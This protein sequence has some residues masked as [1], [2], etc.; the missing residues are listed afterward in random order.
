MSN[1]SSFSI[2][3]I[4]A[5]TLALLAAGCVVQPPLVS[6]ATVQPVPVA[7]V[8]PRVV[9]VYVDPPLYQPPPI[10]VAWAP[11]PMLVERPPSPPFAGAV[12]TGGYW[13]WQGNWIWAAG[14]WATPPEPG[15][16]WVQPYYEHRDGLVVFITGHWSA[17]G[18]AFIPPPP[19]LGLVVSAAAAGVVAGLAP[20]GPQ[21]V[22][23]PAP[24]GSRLGLIV[25]APVGT[26]PAVVVS[27]P[28]VTNVGMRV[29]N[30]TIYNVT[31]KTTN[32]T[33]VTNINDT[34]TVTV[35]APA[36][37][38]ASGRP[39]EA[40]VPASAHLAAALPPVVHAIAPVPDSAKPVAALVPGHQPAASRPVEPARQTITAL[41]QG[42]TAP[43]QLHPPV[44]SPPTA[45]KVAEP[46]VPAVASARPTPEAPRRAGPVIS[47][48]QRPQPVAP[49]LIE[50]E[51]QVNAARRSDEKQ[52]SR[53]DE[54]MPRER[55]A[56]SPH[57][58]A[59]H[60]PISSQHGEPLRKEEHRE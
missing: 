54:S 39:F 3:K 16:T 52:V 33:N 59:Q 38:M 10:A 28:P 17:P 20:I 29:Q 24:P 57:V 1:K 49:A 51:R 13:T 21:G 22:F 41:P 53:V 25:P 6:R 9:S 46:A 7:S 31:N 42:P 30:T 4:S 40:A 36:G 58:Q 45:A 8:A 60:P 15:Y 34:R 37:A 27:A 14:R 23:V 32:V 11:P 26:P 18:V 56:L 19:G 2:V 35:V 43:A 12:W 44:A 55:P 5:M 50:R 48:Q 47:G